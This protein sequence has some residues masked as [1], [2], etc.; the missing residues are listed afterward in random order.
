MNGHDVD[1]L[2]TKIAGRRLGV[3]PP[4]LQKKMV[5]ADSSWKKLKRIIRHR[6]YRFHKV[7]F[8]ERLDSGVRVLDV[9]CGNNSPLLF[10]T[11][12]PDLIYTGLDICDY[13]QTVGSADYADKYIIAPPDVF[14]NLV[15]SFC[16]KFDAVVSSHNLEHCES[17]DEVLKAM[18]RALKLNGKIFLSFPCEQSRSF[19][20]RQGT[21]NFFD[22]S[23]HKKVPDF[24]E[25]I[26]SLRSNGISI[27]MATRRCR[28]LPDFLIGLINEPMSALKKQ[29][30]H[31]TWALYGFE[32][33][34]WGTRTE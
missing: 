21:L 17:P 6:L 30:M 31:G 10:K 15:D 18:G 23:T 3:R 25:I 24:D 33:I 2:L 19:P 11:L 13:N 7:T 27:D 28:P 20:S 9:G 4:L 26:S 8:I 16:E 22:D 32:S 5:R 1:F 34:I 12:R 14:A 29:V